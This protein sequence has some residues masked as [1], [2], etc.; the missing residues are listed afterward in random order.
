MSERS[1]HGATSHSS[2]IDGTVVYN[3]SCDIPLGDITSYNLDWSNFNHCI[4][5]SQLWQVVM[6]LIKTVCCYHHLNIL[7]MMSD[8][9]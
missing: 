4:L 2:V 6:L 8:F 9:P 5:I 3:I 1:Y 7:H